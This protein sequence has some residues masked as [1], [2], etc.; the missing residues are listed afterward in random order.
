VWE[1]EGNFKEMTKNHPG[2]LKLDKKMENF[3]RL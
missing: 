3:L 2:S 1:L